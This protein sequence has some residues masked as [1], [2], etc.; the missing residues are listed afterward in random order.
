MATQR[1]LTPRI[2]CIVLSGEG[3][4][5]IESFA[6]ACMRFTPQIALRK[7]GSAIFLEVGASHRLF[8]EENL[9]A[10]LIVLAH[11]LGW[12]ASRARVALASSAS[13]AFV[14]TRYK[15]YARSR[16]LKDLPLEALADFAT[17]F[18]A[19]VEARASIDEMVQRLKKLGLKSVG[20]FS[21]LPPADLASRFGRQSVRLVSQVWEGENL[22]AWPGF[23]PCDRVKERSQLDSEGSAPSGAPSLDALLF[24]IKGL[25][26][27][28]M[29]RLRGRA[30]RVA[31]LELRFELERWSILKS[32]KRKY[33][34]ALPLPQGSTSGLLP[35]LRESLNT[36]VEREPF[37]APLIAIELEITETAPG[38]GSQRDFFSQA[39]EEAEAFDALLARLAQ[40]LGKSSVFSAQLVERYLPE[41]AY[42][43]FFP[44]GVLDF[45]KQVMD[46]PARPARVLKKP[47]PLQRDGAWLTR[48]SGERFRVQR[49]EGPERIASEWWRDPRGEGVDRD[50]F[51][52]WTES[53]ERLWIFLN[54]KAPILSARFYLHGYFD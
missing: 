48:A 19:D 7:G 43:R 49:W 5:P 4:V 42:V 10:R 15:E 31:A 52:V 46:L 36:W 14:M 38:R 35:L 25:V 40:K 2:A 30:E 16:N 26:D 54:R 20:D 45:E 32:T 50:Y 12:D 47:E 28:A 18:A 13:T 17:P 41:R 53:G 39:E 8:S 3:R 22:S 1:R 9:C 27:R 24:E 37:L 6:E 11:R 21:I 34:L 44:N 29:A 23:K 33:A 51:R